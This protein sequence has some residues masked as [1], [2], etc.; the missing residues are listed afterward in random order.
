MRP[1]LGAQTHDLRQHFGS[2]LGSCPASDASQGT[3]ARRHAPSYR[4]SGAPR[5]C[6][7]GMALPPTF[8]TR[9]RTS[10]DIRRQSFPAASS[11]SEDT[12]PVHQPLEPTSFTA[13]KT[14][15]GLPGGGQS[16]P[17]QP[18]TQCQNRAAGRCLR[19]L[20]LHDI[21]T[22]HNTSLQG[23]SRLQHM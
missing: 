17:T 16:K 21:D 18:D 10:Y 5:R 15:E 3:G 4:G 11:G 14:L 6:P 20:W 1:P 22:V 8:P 13:K 9:S 12:G 7:L 19:L 23:P 2:A